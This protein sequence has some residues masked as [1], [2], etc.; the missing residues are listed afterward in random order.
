VINKALELASAEQRKTLDEN[1]GKKDSVAEAKCK[2]IFNDLKIDQLY[3]E[4]EE[5]VAKD[6]KAKISQVD[7]SHGF[8]ADVLTAFV[9]KF[10]K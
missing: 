6:F 8:K 7:E 9:N 10:Y 3:H 1:Y 5:S 4:Y 2:K